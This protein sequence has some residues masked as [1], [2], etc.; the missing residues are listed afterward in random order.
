L[1]VFKIALSA[2][3]PD[4]FTLSNQ[5]K[6]MTGYR[7]SQIRSLIGFEWL[8]ERWLDVERT[9]AE[10]RDSTDVDVDNFGL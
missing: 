1:A 2:G 3:Y 4:G 10:R 8:L 5:L 9:R 6:R 7:P